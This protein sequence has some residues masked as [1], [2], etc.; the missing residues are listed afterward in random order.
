MNEATEAFV[1]GQYEVR[2]AAYH[3]YD[4]RCP[5]V[6]RRVIAMI[7]SRLPEATVEH[8]GSTAVPGCAGKGVVDLMVVYP[9]GKLQ[10][11]K[12]AVDSLG[13]QHWEGPDA[14]GD[15]RP[16]RI[17]AVQ[18]DGTEFRLHVHLIAADDPE[19]ARQRAFRDKLRADPAL[20]AAYCARKRE[21]L[22]SGVT[23]GPHYADAKT[24]FIMGAVSE[25]A[26][27]T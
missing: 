7:A 14:F 6:A 5:E 3:P 9:P 19:V 10:D 12:D 27:R 26:H 21:I 15:D 8:I 25:S 13:F 20:V 1:I 11:A 17:G 18:Y 24:E 16:V 2:P 4:P 22:E 23:Y